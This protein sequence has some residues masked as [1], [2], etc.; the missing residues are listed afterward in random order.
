MR[1]DTDFR[2]EPQVTRLPHSQRDREDKVFVL[3]ATAA[4]LIFLVVLFLLVQEM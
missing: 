3:F 2:K 1:C 4:L